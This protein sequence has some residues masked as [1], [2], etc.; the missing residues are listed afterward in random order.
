[1]LKLEHCDVRCSRRDSQAYKAEYK[2]TLAACVWAL[3]RAIDL[4]NH[5]GKRAVTGYEQQKTE[6]FRMEDQPTVIVVYWS[7]ACD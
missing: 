4:I 6:C 2:A 1:M 5:L 7:R 3:G